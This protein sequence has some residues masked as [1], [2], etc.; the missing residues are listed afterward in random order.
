MTI[1][2][3]ALSVVLPTRN[4]ADNIVEVLERLD[5]LGCCDEIVVVDDGDDATVQRALSAGERLDAKVLAFRRYG[6]DRVGGLGTAITDGLSR[7]T[8]RFVVVMDADLQHP[9]E[10]V[11]ALVERLEGADLVIASRFN[12]DSV[13]GGLSPVRRV[14]SRIA[15]GLA[16]R[17]F[18]ER[19]AS[20][21]DPMSGFFAFQRSALDQSV[22]HP[23][24][25]KIL[26]E[27]LGTHPHLSVEEV[28][29]EFAERSGGQSKAGGREAVR[30]GRH[31][32]DLR[33]RVREGSTAQAGDG[34]TTSGE[35]L[36]ILVNASRELAN[37]ASGGS[38]VYMDI[39]MRGLTA[40]GHE[41][42][43]SAGGPVGDRPYTTRSAGSTLGQFLKYPFWYLRHGRDFDLVVDVANG[44]TFYT[45][46]FRRGATLCVV[47]H[48]H[49]EMWAEWFAPPV[50]A[51]GRFLER[52][53]MPL[54]YRS[55][56]FVAVSE[57]TRAALESLGVDEGRISIVYNATAVPEE[58]VATTAVAPLFVAV[59]R[60]VP[61]KQF[62]LLLERWPEVRAATGGELVIVG[63]GPERERLEPLL[64]EGARLAG[65]VS[66]E[67]R[68]HLLASATVLLH[69][70]YVEGWGLV[71]M[72][73]AAQG[74]PSIGFDVPGV[75]DSVTDHDTG[76]ICHDLDHMVKQWISVGRDPGL[77]AR[78]G[79][80]ARERARTFGEDGLIEAFEQ[81]AL[82]AVSA[83]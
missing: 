78:F 41:V 6:S 67:E 10:L 36:R 40:R 42:T 20:I 54:L 16:F 32:L 61:H 29:F 57:S 50:A 1:V 82:A 75:R 49:T 7:S 59:G 52:R 43:L 39:V 8:G 73:A 24:G 25:Y 62:H 19:L 74:T 44:L 27:I 77:A 4:E 46:V 55:T 23:H 76:W 31:L 22:L 3:T 17:I 45:P 37:E 12:W 28:P 64:T 71:V 26:L 70:S 65:R 51:A 38:E 15:G 53:M 72:E 33:R 56:P 83:R 69:P 63:E 80:A 79:A 13:I 68:D 81:A 48:V 34:R 11:P 66:D 14:V 18:G 21:S 47:H 58:P 5:A 35:P 60:L 9:P 30:Y 2:A